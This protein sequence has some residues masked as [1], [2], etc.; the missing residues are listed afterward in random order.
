MALE[1]LIVEWSKGRPAWQRQVMRR[2]ATGDVLTDQDYDRLVEDI[3]VGKQI[4]EPVFGLEQLP[5]TGSEDPAV[6]LVSIEKPEHVNALE[7]KEP[8]T[9][10]PT[11]LTIIY[12]DN[13]SGKSGYARLL[14]RITRARHQEDVLSDVFRDTAVAKPTAIVTVRIGDEEDSL[15]WP[16]PARPE[17]QRMLFYDG[18]C[19]NAYISTESDF[20][21]RP[22]ALFVMDGLIEACVALRSRI[23]S[24]LLANTSG[25]HSLPFVSEDV[26]DTDAGKFLTRLSGSSSVNTLD[27]LIKKLDEATETIDDLKAQEARL[28]NADTSKE[29]QN[30]TRQSEKL[31]ALRKHLERLNSVFGNDGLATLQ[32]QR[33]T[34]KVLDEAASVL[35]RSFD[36]EPLPGVGSSPWKTLWESARRF[37]EAHA[38]P[39]K[40]F[41]VLNDDVR[42]VLCQQS[43][44]AEVRERFSRFEA[45]VKDDTQVR[46]EEARRVHNHNVETLDTLVISPEAIANNLKDLET[47]HPEIVSEL[48]ELL[49]K[50]ES[51]REQTREALTTPEKISRT[52][53]DLISTIT[54]LMGASELT[55]SAAEDLANPDMVQT[56]LAELIRR[57]TE[58]E[59]LQAIKKSRNAIVNEIARLKEC[60]VLDAAKSAAATGPIT[61]KILELS[62][63]SITEVVRDTFTR[64][65]DRL[66]LER[67]TIARTRADKGALLHQP[68]LVGA[69]QEVTLPRVFSEG[70][71]TALG[72]A[73]FFTEA[74]ATEETSSKLERI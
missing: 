50:C 41:P 61:K 47:T 62:E 37:S 18:A 59:L 9:I 25:A 31:D 36:S 44:Q 60:D 29:R 38:Y 10:E 55:K 30:L 56:Q 12:G 69:R 68:K 45:F 11:G 70:E 34:C 53:I 5:Q 6:Y 49:K 48:R 58:L 16:A 43:L 67:V 26:R 52:G 66:R 51:V 2:V 27:K 4:P 57:R 8:L 24:K 39:Q 1:E 13:A 33:D 23:D 20:P 54:R 42:C 17:L 71:R 19:G 64:E 65:A 74:Q 40:Q 3:L 14:K 7:S 15:N 28:R 73:A 35:A 21:Y 63:E 22:S 32:G 46:L 72:L